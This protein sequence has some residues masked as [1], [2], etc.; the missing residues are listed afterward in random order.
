MTRVVVPTAM[1][2]SFIFIFRWGVLGNILS[3]A[4]N[5]IGIFL[6]ALFVVSGFM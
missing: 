5:L 3:V 1:I 2:H 4:C 6:P